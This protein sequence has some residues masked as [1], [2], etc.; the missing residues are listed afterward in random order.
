MSKQDKIE[1]IHNLLRP[2]KNGLTVKEVE[3]LKSR[4]GENL[5]TWLN[6]DSPL[7]VKADDTEDTA[8]K[9]LYIGKKLNRKVIVIRRKIV[10][11]L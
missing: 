8:Q 4:L 1:T 7:V 3:F 5:Q 9:I 11:S 2:G 10:E 6:S